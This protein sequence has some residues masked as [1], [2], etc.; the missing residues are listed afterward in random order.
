MQV[1]IQSRI[2]STTTGPTDFWQTIGATAESDADSIPL[3]R[4]QARFN[5]QLPP[6]EY[7]VVIVPA[8]PP[9]PPAP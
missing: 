3:T 1:I 7:R 2:I 5:P 4:K 9:P 6:G 8:D